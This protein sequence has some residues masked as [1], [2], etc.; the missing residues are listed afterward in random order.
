[1]LDLLFGVSVIGTCIGAIKERLE[2]P[3]PAENWAN[4]ELQNKD[5]ADGVPIEQ[6]I[7]NARNGKYKVA[8]VK[9]DKP[10]RAADGSIIIENSELYYADC[11]KYG[12]CQIQEWKEQ[13]RYNLPPEE[14]E[15]KQRAIEE[16]YKRLYSY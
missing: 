11:R 4:K 7:K 3:I 12:W 5:I 8:P 14:L 6:R 10:H 16:R 9:Y 1:M 15:K 13:G 2:T